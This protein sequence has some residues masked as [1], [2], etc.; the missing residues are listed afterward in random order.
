MVVNTAVMT[1]GIKG[2]FLDYLQLVKGCPRGMSEA[3]HLE[4]VA[5]WIAD[6][7]KEH[8][9]FAVYAA[10]LNREGEVRGSD[11]AIMAADAVY[12][13]R[14]NQETHLAY[15]ECRVSRYF[16]SSDIG[17]EGCPALKMDMHGPHYREHME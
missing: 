1:L 15:M 14:K 12:Y 11:G 3:K 16:E 5:Q 10:Q 17:T 8:K 7:C 6:I 13:L 2:F 4:D 9:I